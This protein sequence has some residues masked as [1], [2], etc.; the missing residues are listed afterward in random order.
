MRFTKIHSLGNDFLVLDSREIGPAADFGDFARRACDRHI[1]VGADG[2]I[3]ITIKDKEAGIVHFRIFNAD[4]TEP[5]VSGN[6][7]RCAAASLYYHQKVN[8]NRLTF[9][10]SAGERE[11]TLIEASLSRYLIRVE[12]GVPRLT[13]R[14]IPFDDGAFHERVI[15]YPLSINRKTYFITLVSVGNPHCAVFVDRFPARIEWHQ[16]G[17]EIESHP[18]FPNRTN[19]EFIRVLNRQ[20][21]EVLF[22]ERGVGETLSSG[23]GSSAAAVASILKGLTDSPVTV[24]TSMGSLLVEWEGQ[25]VYQTGPAEVVFEGS[26][27]NPKV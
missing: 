11:S 15:D 3:I 24:K 16:L 14:D 9:L 26:L 6:G 2:L 10:T 7:L 21:I 5:E 27:L 23:S 22:W 25:K 4:G 19:I 20:E 8:T 12:M 17:R 13:S 1:G 18:F